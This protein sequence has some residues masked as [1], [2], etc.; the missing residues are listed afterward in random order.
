[1]RECAVFG[2]ADALRGEE[3]AAAIVRSDAAID[4]HNLRAWCSDRLV[5]YQQP[6]TILF[7]ES[8]PRNSL[9]KVLRRELRDQI[10]SRPQAKGE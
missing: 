1:V 9:G 10:S 3:V 4:E 2:V 8:L 7:V 5:H 6:R